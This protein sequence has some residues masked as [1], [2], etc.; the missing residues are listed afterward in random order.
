MKLGI[1]LIPFGFVSPF[2]FI[3]L[4][5]LWNFM[6]IEIAIFTFFAAEVLGIFFI[7]YGKRKVKHDFSCRLQE[8]MQEKGG[9]TPPELE[10]IEQ[11]VFGLIKL[12][13]IFWHPYNYDILKQLWILK[14]LDEV[15]WKNT[16]LK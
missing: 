12:Y 7:F 10:Q 11:E 4:D 16:I 5:Y 1:V 8:V 14:R 15:K 6:T 9:I 2:L 13:G 3:P